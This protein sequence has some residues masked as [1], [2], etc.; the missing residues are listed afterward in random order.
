MHLQLWTLWMKHKQ[1][2]CTALVHRWIKSKNQIVS[3]DLDQEEI[4][5][6]RIRDKTWII[7][8]FSYPG[9]WGSP[10]QRP[11]VVSVGPGSCHT[12]QPEIQGLQ[13]CNHDF[14]TNI[15]CKRFLNALLNGVYQNRKLHYSRYGRFFFLTDVTHWIKQHCTKTAIQKRKL[16]GNFISCLR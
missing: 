14:M 6:L 9:F 8:F 16:R 12:G 3:S 13:S 7:F 15:W 11:P 5:Q 10:W 1:H 2:F 4:S